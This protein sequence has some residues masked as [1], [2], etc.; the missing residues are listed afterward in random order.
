M[1]RRLEAGVVSEIDV[2]EI[3]PVVLSLR[4]VDEK[5]VEELMESIRSNGLLQPVVVR[6]TD[7]RQFRLVFGSHRLEAVKRLGWKTIPAMI[8]SVSDEES[9]L[10][11]LTENL[12]R[13]ACVNPIA[14]ARGFK[15]L[16]SKG[17]TIGEMARRIGKSDSYV[18]NRMRVLERL[19]PEL[20]KQIEFP[21][22]NS[23]LTLSHA[24]H[25]STIRDPVQQLELARLVRERNL[26]LHQ[27]ERLTRS[28][29]KA[30]LTPG[31]C[32]CSKCSNYACSLYEHSEP[33]RS[34]ANKAIVK[35]FME[36]V[37][38][39]RFDLFDELC[40]QG[41]IWH[42]CVWHA[43]AST[44]AHTEICGLDDF[45]K[46]VSEFHLNN[47]DL[48][49]VIQDMIAD[50]D[51]VAVRY[52]LVGASTSSRTTVGIYRIENGK[53][54]EEWLLDDEFRSS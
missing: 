42:I 19:H 39:K 16:V 48:E 45:K 54:A 23:S 15:N 32:L 50:E 43:R 41:Y 35:R 22:G 1:S 8:R 6:P 33:E 52:S 27:L 14:E 24:E 3:L 47:P 46:T 37:N 11:S 10:I 20:K 30:R 17:W 44:I 38:T 2:Q 18:C 51:R 28:T 13:N 29:E 36:A 5:T 12:Q 26:S 40:S 34:N 31:R 25:L 4:P 9:F 21:R 53:L 7:E 49:V